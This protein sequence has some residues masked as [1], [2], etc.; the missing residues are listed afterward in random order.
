MKTG[1]K[2]LLTILLA[3]LAVLLFGC[4]KPESGPEVVVANA[5]IYTPKSTVTTA[6]LE[7]LYKTDNETFFQ[8]KLPSVSINLLE[9]KGTAMATT[10]CDES[11]TECE[12]KFNLK[13]VAAKRVANFTMLHEMC[14]VKTW[15][16]DSDS[17]GKVWRTCM[18]QL[19]SV[20]AFREILI[21]NYSE[22]M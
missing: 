4:R 9:M 22:G 8:N 13:Y 5:A 18:L 16:K 10:V 6:Y 1:N 12:L 7:D 19:D 11:A 20:G 14:H 3:V 15:D 17:H 2:I 21:D